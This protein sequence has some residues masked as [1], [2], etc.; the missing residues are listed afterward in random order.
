MLL[1][2]LCLVMMLALVW[3]SVSSMVASL[4]GMWGGGVVDFLLGSFAVIVGV[5]G[6][7]FL[8]CRP[9]ISLACLRLLAR[10]TVLGD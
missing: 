1:L 4:R 10:P 5:V 7:R 9:D 2:G 3:S 6:I 8:A